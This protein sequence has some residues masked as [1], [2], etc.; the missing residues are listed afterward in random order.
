V[1]EL[2]AYGLE[3]RHLRPVF[4]AAARQADVVEGAAAA[5]RGSGS[6][7]RERASARAQEIAGAVGRLSQAAVRLSLGQRG[8]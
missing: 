3:L 4:L 2:A 1:S 6:A 8:L 5:L 7:G